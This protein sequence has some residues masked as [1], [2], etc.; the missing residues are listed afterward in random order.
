[1]KDES[2]T[3]NAEEQEKKET[4]LVGLR[5]ADVKEESDP[6]GLDSLIP[7]TLRK[8]EMI[9]GKKDASAK[10]KKQEEEEENKRFLKSKR[11]ALILC[12]ETAA[13]RYKL[14]WYFL[15]TQINSYQFNQ[16]FPFSF[17]LD[18]FNL[19]NLINHALRKKERE[20]IK[21]NIGFSQVPNGHRHLGKACL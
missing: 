5:E 18:S 4:S 1:M 7:N 13:R 12:L 6:F 2:E 3:E 11:E 10:I 9:K 15:T 8:D 19:I 16:S 17:S 20:M 21:L 14:P